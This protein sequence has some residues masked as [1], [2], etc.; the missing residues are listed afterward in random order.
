MKLRR[1]D[2]AALGVDG[3]ARALDRAPETVDA[4]IHRA[5]R[6]SRRGA[7][8]RGRR[9]GGADRALRSRAAGPGGAARAAAEFD[10]AERQVGEATLAALRYAAARIEA[11]P[12]RG[13][14]ADLAHDR[15]LRLAT[16]ARKC[17][18]WSGCGIYV[19]GGPR[20]VSLHGAD[21]GGARAR[22]G[23]AEIVLVSPPGA[24][25]SSMPRCWPPRAWRG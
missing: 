22:G 5:W 21:D 25:G 11:F 12:P 4:A 23:R 16:R 14:A 6:H 8:A 15:R 9:A 2:T 17:G 24:D 20:R 19:P 7:R 10:A 13:H 18:R 3:V 1:L